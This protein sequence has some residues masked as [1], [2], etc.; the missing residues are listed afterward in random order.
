GITKP[1]IRRLSRRG[2][3]KRTS[4]LM[5]EQTRAMLKMFLD[6]VLHDATLYTKHGWR[7]TVTTADITRALRF[8]T[9]RTLY[10]C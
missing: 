8:R 2:G 6:S 5:Y 9:G 10:N 1:V 4:N 7:Y 3:V